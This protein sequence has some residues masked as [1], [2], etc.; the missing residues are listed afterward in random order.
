MVIKR[1]AKTARANGREIAEPY[2]VRRM[3]NLQARA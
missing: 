1:V 2:D 3:L